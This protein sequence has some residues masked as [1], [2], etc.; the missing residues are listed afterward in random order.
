MN[1]YLFFLLVSLLFTSWSKS[2]GIIINEFAN[3]GANEWV[4]LL[5]LGNP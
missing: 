5:V 1:K 2:Q 3:D 4:E